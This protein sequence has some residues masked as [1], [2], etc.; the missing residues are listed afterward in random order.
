MKNAQK[1]IK[2]YEE[3]A[4]ESFR[5]WG[6]YF[7]PKSWED[8]YAWENETYTKYLKKE[9]DDVA[10]TGLYIL[11]LNT[12]TDF[13]FYLAFQKP[14]YGLL[15]NV[16]YQDSRQ[17]LLNSG[18]SASG[19]DHCDAFA[20]TADSFACNDFEVIDH[21]FPKNLPPSKGAYYTEVSVNLLKVLYYDTVELKKDALEKAK[22]FLSKKITAWEKYVI[23]YFMALMGENAA[24][25]SDCLQELC[26]AYQRIGTLFPIQKCFA[27]KIHGMYRFARI[28]DEDFFN[29][30]TRPRHP[31]F[32]EEFELWQKEQGYPKGELFYRRP[33][34]LDYMNKIFEAR[35]P[36]VE[37]E[38][39][40]YPSGK[41]VYKNTEKFSRDLTENVKKIL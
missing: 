13:G 10:R 29:R 1:Y 22:K 17:A 34:K 30:I 28:I 37:L 36:I 18:G 26:A 24:D 35:L 23:L 27:S 11:L 12:A 4:E 3:R 19:T 25:A 5:N 2:L 16:L 33:Q 21:F 20:K 15:N 31:S 38:E 9:H 40:H 8:L 41:K 6:Y 14:D 7:P 39:V 32:S